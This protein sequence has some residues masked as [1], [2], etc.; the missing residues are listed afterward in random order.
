MW[1]ITFV[2]LSGAVLNTIGKFGV[3]AFSPVLLNIAMIGMALFGAD[4]FEQPDVALAW[5]ISSADCC[6]FL[7][8]IPFMKKEGLLVKARNGRGKT[9]G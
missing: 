3:M 5:G 7:F 4:Y 6:Q 8:Q 9:K 1:F 2:A